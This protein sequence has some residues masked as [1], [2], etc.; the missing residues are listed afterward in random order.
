MI[1]FCYL[2][3]I[4]R[5][6]LR[7]QV[8]I[9]HVLLSYSALYISRIVYLKDCISQGLYISRIAYLKDC[10]SQGLYILRIVYLKDCIFQ[11]LYI[12]R[13]V[14]RVRTPIWVSLFLGRKARLK[15]Q[16]RIKKSKDF[17]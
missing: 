15:D 5:T 1:R 7:T 9:V 12:S 16:L 4:Y 10:I 8:G 17:A 14:Y 6:S 11:G 2:I 3:L 13:I